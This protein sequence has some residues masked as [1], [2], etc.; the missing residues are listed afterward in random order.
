[1]LNQITL[2]GGSGYLQSLAHGELITFHQVAH[3]EKFTSMLV[4]VALIVRI[5]NHWLNQ[6][7]IG[8][9]IKSGVP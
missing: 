5:L 4:T 8:I 7:V 2:I 9:L 6:I 3:I 1:M